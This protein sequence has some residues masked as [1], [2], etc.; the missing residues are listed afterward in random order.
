MPNQFT[1]VGQYIANTFQWLLIKPD[2]D[3]EYYYN[4]LGA[5]VSY[6]NLDPVGTVKMYHPYP[7]SSN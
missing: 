1:L 4:G 7:I 5:T 3:K 6:I 2:K